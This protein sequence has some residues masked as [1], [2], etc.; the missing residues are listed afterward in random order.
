MEDL[1]EVV[2]VKKPT[3]VR[4]GDT[5]QECFMYKGMSECFDNRCFWKRNGECPIAQELEE[6]SSPPEAA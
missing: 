1:Q 3:V 5:V 6:E 4:D 2:K